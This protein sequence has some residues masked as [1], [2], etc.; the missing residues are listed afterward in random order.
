MPMTPRPSWH[1]L[2]ENS[3]NAHAWV[4]G[5]PNIG[6]DTWIGAF[7]VID[8]SGGLSIGSNCDI[9][10]G[11]QIYTHSTVKRALSDGKSDIE[12]AATSIGS[13]C[14]IGAGAIIL[15]GADLGDH[16]VV[17]AGAV[18]PQFT[19]AP[20]FSLLLGVPARIVDN[21]ARNLLTTE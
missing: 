16:C 10:A 6:S 13:H 7:C 14:H 21:G 3:F 20:A 4:I 12:R 9:S 18:V 8:G 5:E 2:P 15:M 17:A 19:R 1:E 11:A